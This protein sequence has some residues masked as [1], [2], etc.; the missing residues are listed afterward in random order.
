MKC[1]QFG[2]ELIEG[3]AMPDHVHLC[4]SIPP[5]YSVANTVG[6]IKGKSAVRI[7]RDYIG[8]RGGSKGFSIVPTLWRGNAYPG[9]LQRPVSWRWSVIN[10][11]PTQS[12]GT[13]N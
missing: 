13:M 10:R 6:R 1:H 11:I 4:L 8:K 9:T 12:V 5:K 3:H 2:V 7:H